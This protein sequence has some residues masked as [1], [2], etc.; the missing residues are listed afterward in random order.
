M[1]SEK[2]IILFDGVCNLCNFWIRFVS[3]RDKKKQFEFVT[4]QSEKGKSLL[5]RS[6]ISEEIDS[7]VL[8]HKGRVFVESDAA[9]EISGSLNFPWK[10]LSVFKVIPKKWR[11]KLYKRIA[12]N[13][14]K[15][16]GKQDNCS[17]EFK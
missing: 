12:K 5:A 3:M 15:W 17:Y 13:R 1:H 8:I 14:Y 11:D 9:L 16:F 2:Q 6:I 10:L 7:V 4:L